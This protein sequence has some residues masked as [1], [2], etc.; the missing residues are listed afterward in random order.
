[1]AN[2]NATS[3]DDGDTRDALAAADA[4]RDQ[5]AG[6]CAEGIGDD[7]SHRAQADDQ[8]VE[9]GEASRPGGLNEN[10]QRSPAAPTTTIPD[11]RNIARRK[12][13]EQWREQPVA[14]RRHRHLP[15]QQRPA[16]QRADRGQDHGDRDRDLRRRA[17]TSHGPRRRTARANATSS[18][19]RQHAHH[20][21]R[22]EHIEGSR[23]S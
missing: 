13:A 10:Q 15:H 9:R 12:P 18:L 3:L 11:R 21:D 14:R 7:R 6:Q 23:R 5:A 8:I 4:R 22:S 19:P 2:T 16:V 20:D 17:P 1:M